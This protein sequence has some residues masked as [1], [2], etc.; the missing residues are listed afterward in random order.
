VSAR[1]LIVAVAAVALAFLSANGSNASPLERPAGSVADVHI[2][3]GDFLY[4]PSEV[5]VAR[6]AT[7]T[8]DF[9]G[10]SHHTVTDA[11]GMALYDSGSVGAGGP[12]FTVTVQGA[13]EYRFTCIPHPWMGGHIAVPMRVQPR[14]GSRTDLYTATWAAVV[15]DAGFVYDVELRRPGGHWRPFLSDQTGTGAS[16]ALRAGDGTYRFRARL[17]ALAGAAAAWSPVSLV[18]VH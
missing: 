3:V 12:S 18:R 8:F 11:S 4:T 10:P 7:V 6:G 9:V 5:S 17:R 15:P 13:G 1:R 16:F 2:A 14:T